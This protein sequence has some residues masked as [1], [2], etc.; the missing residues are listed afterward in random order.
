MLWFHQCS[1]WRPCQLVEIVSSH[2]VALRTYHHVPVT[3]RPGAEL[4]PRSRC[5]HHKQRLTFLEWL[6]H[7]LTPAWCLTRPPLKFLGELNCYPLI[8]SCPTPDV[9]HETDS[10]VSQARWHKKVWRLAEPGSL[11]RENKMGGAARRGTFIHLQRSVIIKDLNWARCVCVVMSRKEFWAD[12]Q[13]GCCGWRSLYFVGGSHARQGQHSCK[14]WHFSLLKTTC[15]ASEGAGETQ[16]FGR[17]HLLGGV[18]NVELSSLLS[19]LL[20]ALMKAGNNLTAQAGGEDW[21]LWSGAKWGRNEGQRKYLLLSLPVTSSHL[22]S[23]LRLEQL[24]THQV[25]HFICFSALACG[26]LWPEE[27]LKSYTMKIVPP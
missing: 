14:S 23:G 22:Q 7:L 20:S 8:I 25:L 11:S 6:G 15:P 13:W 19:C 12:Q 16:W 27:N 2:E 24:T 9:L 17:N 26:L 4:S 5:S 1:Q 18:R 21:G 3:D 10:W